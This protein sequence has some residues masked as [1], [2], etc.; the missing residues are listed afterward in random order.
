MTLHHTDDLICPL[1][2]EKLKGVHEKLQAWFLEAKKEFRNIHIACAWRGQED[3]EKAY[4]EGKT[5]A[6]FP[7]SKH[8]HTREGTPC[9][10]ALDVFQLVDGE[11]VFDSKFYACLN[12]LNQSLNCPILWGGTFKSIIDRDHFELITEVSSA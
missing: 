5:R 4:Q 9:S 3:Q 10:L 12:D 6:H 11:A 8:N 1:C 7:F 2:E